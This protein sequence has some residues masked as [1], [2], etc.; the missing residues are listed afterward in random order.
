MLEKIDRNDIPGPG[1]RGKSP[2]R[3]FGEE[4][5]VAFLEG[6]E[7][8]EV[9]EVSGWPVD[10]GRDAAWNADRAVRAIDA[11]AYYMERD[12]DLRP[13]VKLSRRGARVFMERREQPPAARP[14][15]EPR[16]EGPEGEAPRARP[17]CFGKRPAA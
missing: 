4:T 17:D 14:D 16:K 6:Y 12:R 7:P 8:G 5:L 1:G 9:A 13:L 3:A 11:A 2:A 15:G 10:D